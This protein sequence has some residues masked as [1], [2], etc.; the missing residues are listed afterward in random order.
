MM[1]KINCKYNDRGAWCKNIAIKRSV[2]GLGARCCI[3]FNYGK[4]KHCDLQVI[5]PKPAAPPPPPKRTNSLIIKI[6]I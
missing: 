6:I 2:F 3:L 1:H 4:L 5:S